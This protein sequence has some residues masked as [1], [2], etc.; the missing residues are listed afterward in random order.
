MGHA[1]TWGQ[2]CWWWGRLGTHDRTYTME[3]VTSAEREREKYYSI[4]NT[5]KYT[6]CHFSSHQAASLS[7]DHS[8]CVPLGRTLYTAV[9]PPH[10]LIASSAP[11]L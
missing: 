11:L 9:C 2:M 10:H 1:W 5:Q 6:C 8:M 7:C 3:Q 4:Y